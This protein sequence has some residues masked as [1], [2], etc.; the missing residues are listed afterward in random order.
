M[1]LNA[2]ILQSFLGTHRILEHVLTP[3]RKA[4]H[5]AGR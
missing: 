4:R 2:Q 3:V 5:E 1:P